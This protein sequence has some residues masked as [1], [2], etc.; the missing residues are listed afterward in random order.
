M[1]P[2]PNVMAA[3][4]NPR[5]KNFIMQ[6]SSAKAQERFGEAVV[7]RHTC[8]AADLPGCDAP[9]VV[10][11]I[12]GGEHLPNTLLVLDIDP[13]EAAAGGQPDMDEPVSR[14]DEAGSG[15]SLYAECVRSPP[16]NVRRLNH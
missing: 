4:T 5:D 8:Q 12:C 15:K 13:V 6:L 7:I 3:R 10:V 14:G 11:P 2:E 1:Q 16:L 9:I